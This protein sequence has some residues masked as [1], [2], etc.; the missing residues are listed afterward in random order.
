MLLRDM[1]RKG[2]CTTMAFLGFAAFPTVANAYFYNTC[3]GN[4]VVWNSGWTNMWISTTSMPAGSVWDTRLQNAMWHWNNVKGSKFNFYVGR[5]TDGTHSDNNG[6]TE[7]FFEG[8]LGT[9]T[10]AVTRFRSHCYWLF[11]WH[12]G[13]DEAD[14]AFNSDQSWSVSSLNYGNLGSPY[15]FESVALH[16]LGH[17]LGLNHEDR[18]MATLNS[19]YP[20]SGPVGQGKEWD[21]LPDD[22][23]GVRF[24]YPDSTAETDIAS[25][26]FKRTGSGTSNLVASTTS[27]VRGTNV[28]VE[29]TFHNLSTSRVDF[30][31]GFY[32]STNNII[33][34]GDRLLGTNTGA[35]ASPG[36]SFTS[37]RTLTIPSSIAP[38][39]YWLGFIVD[40]DNKIS[41]TNEANNPMEM[42]RAI[43]VLA[44]G[45]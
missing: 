35:W 7:V 34:T 23:A 11:G 20:N 15:S 24:L 4:K 5:D 19:Y 25:S 22:R 28:N 14:V 43:T 10:L 40:Y 41:E 44:A 18:W 21:P 26:V 9:N 2:G 6:T 8:G 33:S 36:A 32:L 31:I 16:E 27:A 17:V 29:F 13:I 30:N 45:S 38:G 42:P 12:Y 1:M 37:T 3:S 39:Q